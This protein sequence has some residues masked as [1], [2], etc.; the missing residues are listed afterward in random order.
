[1]GYE[2]VIWYNKAS[3]KQDLKFSEVRT[4]YP[5]PIHQAHLIKT[6]KYN[7][8]GNIMAPTMG[9][10]LNLVFKARRGYENT[11]ISGLYTLQKHLNL[12][13]KTLVA[14][15]LWKTKWTIKLIYLNKINVTN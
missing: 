4:S 12:T 2:H 5:C 7:L 10:V 15:V 11:R 9:R 8:G 1:M 3:R 14:Q 6:T 13:R